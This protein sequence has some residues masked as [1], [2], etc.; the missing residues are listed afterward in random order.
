MIRTYTSHI[1]LIF[2]LF[3][4]SQQS[5]HA[6]DQ[7]RFIHVPHVKQLAQ[8]EGFVAG[9]LVKA[10]G[11]YRPIETITHGMIVCACDMQNGVQTERRVMHVSKVIISDGV[12]I[13]SDGQIIVAGSAQRFFVPSLARWV[14]VQELSESTAAQDAF[15]PKNALIKQISEPIEV[16]QLLVEIDHTF[17]VTGHDLL[18][19]NAIP[20][21]AM[22]AG[23]FGTS[24]FAIIAAPVVAVAVPVAAGWIIWTALA[25]QIQKNKKKP[26]FAPSPCGGGGG[27]PDD[28]DDPEKNKNKKKGDARKKNT[29]SKQE[30]F[31][32]VSNDYEYYRDG[33]YKRRPGAKGLSKKAEYLEW[34]NLHN[35]VEVYNNR[36][37]HEGS[38]DPASMRM[39][40][41]AVSGRNIKNKL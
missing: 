6:S 38:F 2:S 4:L 11:G 21:L 26:N 24:A 22:S 32:K 10:P 20:T 39:Y 27:G 14:T 15:S 9:T 19:H 41:S 23:F 5:V 1:F 7:A 35:D 18:V 17:Y 25:S 40:K 28:P 13:I 33:V 37:L 34:D 30:F 12:Q 8:H 29:I 3:V 16:Y 31:K 36:A